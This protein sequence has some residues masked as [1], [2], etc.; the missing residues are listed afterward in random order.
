MEERNRNDGLLI[1]GVIVL[2]IGLTA[3]G[4]SFNVFPPFV[5]DMFRAMGRA[6]GPLALIVLGVIVIM[7]ASR[8]GVSLPR[9][10]AGTKLYRSR[11]DRMVAGVA[12]GL[13]AYLHVDPLLV[14]LA[15]VVLVLA[16]APGIVIAYIIM[17]VLVPEEPLAPPVAPPAPT[18]PAA[19]SAPP[20]QGGDQPGA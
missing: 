7:I 16:N 8:G 20:T 2:L 18:P 12:G 13:A 14:R 11:S 9:P 17:A 4:R 10:E 3:L 15:I 5:W 1:I 19:P 6:T